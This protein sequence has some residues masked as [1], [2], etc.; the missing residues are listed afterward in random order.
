MAKQPSHS[1]LV[2]AI[3]KL[4]TEHGGFV[5]KHYAGGPIGMNGVADLIGIHRGRG[6][7]I[8][9]K[10]GKDKLTEKQAKF[11]EQW[12]SAG[13]IGIEARDVK[14]VADEL[15]IAMLL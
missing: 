8:E 1:D 11:L 6:V 2:K 3:K 9:V 10:T 5:Y 7:A 14:T 12:R 4:V 13:G 15:G